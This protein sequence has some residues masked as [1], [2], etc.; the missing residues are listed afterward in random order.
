MANLPGL[1][2]LPTEPGLGD[3]LTLLHQRRNFPLE[4]AGSR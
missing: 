3:Q 2:E 1:A 4:I